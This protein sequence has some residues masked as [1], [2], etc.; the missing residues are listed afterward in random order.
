VVNACACRD[1]DATLAIGHVDARP[2]AAIFSAHNDAY[3]RIIDEQQAGRFRPVCASC[4]FYRSIYHQPKSYRRG[5]V[6]TQTVAQYLRAIDR[7]KAPTTGVPESV[8]AGTNRARAGERQQAEQ[9]ADRASLD[10]V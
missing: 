9:Q 5:R 10:R 1:V 8:S 6:P 2:L 7:R 4:D 3:R